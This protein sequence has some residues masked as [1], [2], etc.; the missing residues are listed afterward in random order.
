MVHVWDVHQ[1]MCS[2]FLCVNVFMI[3]HEGEARRK[4]WRENVSQIAA[5][6]DWSPAGTTPRSVC[7]CQ[8]V[9]GLCCWLQSLQGLS[10]GRGQ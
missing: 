6:R 9:Q 7:V 10:P 8:M 1:E 2:A 5:F 3:K 4:W